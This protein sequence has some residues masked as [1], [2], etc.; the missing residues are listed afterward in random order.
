MICPKCKSELA[1]DAMVCPYCGRDLPENA[2][3]GYCSNCGAIAQPNLR[4]CLE[5]GERIK[6]VADIIQ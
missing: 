1:D 5:C 6:T 2:T 4:I 3:I